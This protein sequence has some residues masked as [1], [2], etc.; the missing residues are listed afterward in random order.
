VVLSL[1][2]TP[3]RFGQRP[4]SHWRRSVCGLVAELVG[5]GSEFFQL[6]SGLAQAPVRMDL[7]CAPRFWIPWSS[8]TPCRRIQWTKAT[9]RPGWDTPA[10]FSEAAAESLAKTFPRRCCLRHNAPMKIGSPISSRC[11]NPRIRSWVPLVVAWPR[12]GLLLARQLGGDVVVLVVGC[13]AFRFMRCALL[14]RRFR[15]SQGPPQGRWEA[16]VAPSFCGISLWLLPEM[17]ADPRMIFRGCI[18][19]ASTRRFH[20]VSERIESRGNR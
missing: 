2:I 10:E 14:N 17:G 8:A 20:W 19:V 9:G 18:L 6:P 15:N 13:H 1:P 11:C 12:G 4:H 5:I 7:A 3:P 16:R